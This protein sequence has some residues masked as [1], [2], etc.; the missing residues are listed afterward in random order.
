MENYDMLLNLIEHP[1]KY[2]QDVVL[3]I[4]SN[5]EM[6][7]IYDT[8]CKT[9]SSLNSNDQISDEFIDL[10]WQRLST[11]YSVEPKYRRSFVRRLL[12]SSRIASLA[13]I[14]LT[15]MVALAV[16]I[17]VTVSVIDQK[18]EVT[19]VEMPIEQT[20]KSIAFCDTAIASP[21]DLKVEEAPI[22]FENTSLE[23]ILNAVSEQYDVSVEFK[24]QETARIHLFYKFDARQSLEDIVEQLNT[25]DRID[26]RKEGNTLIVE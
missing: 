5:P 15:S 22:I 8:L 4:L 12:P 9:S 25:F 6:K 26:I 14:I 20:N 2:S 18:S 17:A 23:E 3:E 24:N 10:E 11:E 16:G 7:G 13:V 19:N 21:K 1:D